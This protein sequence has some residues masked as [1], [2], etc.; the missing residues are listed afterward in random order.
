[1]DILGAGATLLGLP[2]S[3]VPLRSP[4]GPRTRPHKPFGTAVPHWV[5][6]DAR[7]A[8]WL[9]EAADAVGF[10]DIHDP[11]RRLRVLKG[12]MRRVGEKVQR[13]AVEER[14]A[15]PEA[16]LA[17]CYGLLAMWCRREWKIASAW[18]AGRPRLLRLLG[19]ERARGDLRPIATQRAALEARIVTLHAEVIAELT[20][21]RPA[22]PRAGQ[23]VPQRV[24]ALLAVLRT[25]RARR[26]SGKRG[27]HDRRAGGHRAGGRGGRS[28][29]KLGTGFHGR[30][31]Q[32]SPLAVLGRAAPA[33]SSDTARAEWPRLP[34]HG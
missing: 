18:L 7:W 31:R 15:P 25:W 33:I 17:E 6:R 26:T 9:K 11:W 27:G 20:G 16:Q 32:S 22:E 5:P 34:R 14:T 12:L 3:Q 4:A 28:G 1:M 10:D 13:A 23:V 24:H 19:L 21:P 30:S 29:A 8:P 2:A